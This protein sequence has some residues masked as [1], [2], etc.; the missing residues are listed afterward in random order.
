[1]NDFEIFAQCW[2]NAV[3]GL[4]G[5]IKRC[6]KPMVTQDALNDMWQE[7]LLDNRFYSV[8]VGDSAQAF[9]DDLRAR[10]PGTAHRVEEMLRDSAFNLG[11]KPGSCIAKVTGAVAS[12]AIA[13][14]Q[15]AGGPKGRAVRLFGKALCGGASALLT[16]STASDIWNGT[17][18]ALI[19]RV[20]KEAAQQLES[21]RPILT[22]GTEGAD[23]QRK[24][25]DP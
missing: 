24:E 13:A 17:K 10:R 1:M 9:L 25:C 14:A 5:R 3:N 20:R 21:F 2:A 19:A 7:E 15:N 4:V 16:V 11:F 12:A 8:T 22:V 23:P 6:D 18:D